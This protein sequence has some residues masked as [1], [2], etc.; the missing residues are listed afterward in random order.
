MLPMEAVEEPTA[1]NSI[2]KTAHLVEVE[3]QG[4]EEDVGALQ[5]RLHL[6]TPRLC[7]RAATLE[8]ILGDEQHTLLPLA[9]F[10]A[11]GSSLGS[12]HSTTASSKAP[13]PTPP[14]QVSVREHAQADAGARACQ[15]HR[16]LFIEVHVEALEAGDQDHLHALLL[17]AGGAAAAAAARGNRRRCIFREAGR[18]TSPAC[19]RSTTFHQLTASQTKPAAPA[20]LLAAPVAWLASH[21]PTVSSYSLISPS[22]RSRRSAASSTPCSRARQRLP[23]VPGVRVSAPRGGA[24][25]RHSTAGGAGAGACR[26]PPPGPPACLLPPAPAGCAAA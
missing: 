17:R 19:S 15:L 4:A 7:A 21:R 9:A 2:A 22:S 6:G 18:H 16:R 8:P 5:R 26:A 14:T 12:L 20:C 13:F 1:S 11:P 10:T 3:E 24:R 25:G 23:G